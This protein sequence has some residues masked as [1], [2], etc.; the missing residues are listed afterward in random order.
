[1]TELQ[2]TRLKD[3]RR[4][5][6]LIRTAVALYQKPQASL[7]VALGDGLRQAA[8]DLFRHPDTRVADLISGHVAATAARCQAAGRVIV[9]QDTTYFAYHQAQIVG[10]GPLNGRAQGLVGHSALALSPEGLPLGVLALR[11][12]GDTA[13]PLPGYPVQLEP[14]VCACESAR[15]I[16]TLKSGLQADKPQME[17]AHSLAHC[18]ATYYLVAWRLLYMT[19]QARITPD[20]PP[21]TVFTELEVQVLEAVS[22]RQVGTLELAVREVARLG[23]YKYYRGKRLPPGVQ[24]AGGAIPDCR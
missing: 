15:W 12:W 4:V 18:L 7:S 22:G 23:R 21:T 24:G 9:A 2:G 17:D 16:V 10:L 11:L 19:Y 1:V 6:I 8:G 14:E 5:N 20:A 13:H 3:R